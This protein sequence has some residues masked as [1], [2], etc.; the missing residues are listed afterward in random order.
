V[1]EQ[2]IPRPRVPA[3]EPDLTP[4]VIVARAR[5][6]IPAIREQ[7]DEAE[8]LGR[9]TPELDKKFTEAG[10]YRMLQPRRFGGYAFDMLTYWKVI[11]AA[12]E[13]DPGGEPGRRTAHPGR[14]LHVGAADHPAQRERHAELRRIHPRRRL[15]PGP[16]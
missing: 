6:L 5:A 10:F 8:K 1:S 2:T 11:M 15:R 16:A 4:E 13:G 12:A 7:Q 3:P 14:Q 9:H